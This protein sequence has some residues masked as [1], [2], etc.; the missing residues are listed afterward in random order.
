[1]A[2]SILFAGGE[3][4]SFSYINTTFTGAR[5]SMTNSQFAYDTTANSFR[6]GYARYAM[7]HMW[8]NN[9]V[10][11]THYIQASFPATTQFWASFRLNTYTPNNGGGAGNAQP[12]RF[13]DAAG[14]VRLKII[15]S[16][17][18]G[19]PN[20]TFT[21]WKGNASGSFTQIGSTSTGRFA[22]TAAGGSYLAVTDK[23]DVSINYNTSGYITF[24]LNGTQ[25][26]T[27]SGDVTTD[28][29]TTLSGLQL[30]GC[31]TGG[32]N[33][34]TPYSA[35][36]EVIVATRDTRNMS[37]ATQ[38]AT[39][40]GNAD[41]FA[42]GTAANL[43]ALTF[44]TSD[45]AP[46]YATAAG[47]IQEY[48]VTPALPSG[49]FSVVS[50]VQHARATVGAS[51]PTKFDFVVRTGGADFTSSP[52][53]APTLVWATYTYNWDTNP[54]TGNAWQVT[55]LAASSSSFNLGLKSVA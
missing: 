33:G 49:S 20:D 22:S 37:V 7:V 44:L 19:S 1:M 50:V 38:V 26:F 27:Y 6:T 31:V 39:A 54:N 15:F 24:Y 8:S 41:T 46:N 32:N 16:G 3:D 35:W 28:S 53:T 47:Q 11:S 5:A 21:V 12:L 9:G 29:T 30:G 14:V 4:L 45:P 17:T 43:A 55:D 34:A 13:V 2:S 51:G 52:D 18:Y 40:N 42:G 36:S 25:T 10:D 23:I 48:T